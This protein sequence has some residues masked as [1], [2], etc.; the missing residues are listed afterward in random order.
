MVT[1]ATL[2][3]KDSLDQAMAVQVHTVPHKVPMVLD[4]VSILA[5]LR[6]LDI[7]PTV[8]MAPMLH[9]AKE[10][11]HPLV[12]HLQ[13]QGW[14]LHH[15]AVPLAMEDTDHPILA[16]HQQVTMVATLPAPVILVAIPLPRLAP[17]VTSSTVIVT[18]TDRNQ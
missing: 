9:L 8:G 6:S 4:L 5:T 16:G 17:A 14:V 2:V 15:L 10:V 3:I 1:L 12:S 7:T 13:V 11:P 18:M